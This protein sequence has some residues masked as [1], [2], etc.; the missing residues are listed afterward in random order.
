MRSLIAPSSIFEHLKNARAW[1]GGVDPEQTW[2][3]SE[4]Q[5]LNTYRKL[6]LSL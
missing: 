2:V 3:S 4:S 1:A 5:D 6:S